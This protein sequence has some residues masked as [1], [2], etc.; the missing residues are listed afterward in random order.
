VEADNPL[1]DTTNWRIVQMLADGRRPREIAPQLFMSLATVNRR[2]LKLRAQVGA[3]NSTHLVALA[4]R[5][6]WID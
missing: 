4:L 6:G 2:L 1:V 5:R 3:N